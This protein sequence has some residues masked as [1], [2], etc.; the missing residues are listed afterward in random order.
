MEVKG[1]LQN[2]RKIK[3]KHNLGFSGR[4][5]VKTAWRSLK[6]PFQRVQQCFTTSVLTT[7][8]S[9]FVL[10]HAS[11]KLFCHFKQCFTRRVTAANELNCSSRG[12]RGRL[13]RPHSLVTQRPT[14]PG[15]YQPT[16]II[17]ISLSSIHRKRQTQ[18]PCFST[19][20]QTGY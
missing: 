2:K 10:A 8:A 7:F 19:F 1:L 6:E 4:N 5:E 16:R 3:C 9:S 12:H 17:T 15:V 20:S 14:S 11:Y 13:P 18:I